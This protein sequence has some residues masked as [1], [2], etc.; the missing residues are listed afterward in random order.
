MALVRHQFSRLLVALSVM[1]CTTVNAAPNEQTFIRDT[2]QKYQLPESWLQNTMAKAH[3]RPAVIKLITK[4][5]EAKPWF[6]YRP[7]FLTTAR[8]N[9]GV[10]FYKQHKALFTKASARY[11]VPARYILAI[12]AVETYYG[13]HQGTHPVLDSLYTLGFDYPPRG[14][15]FRKELASFLALSHEQGWQPETI[16]GS[17]AGA[18]G[19]SQF[20]SSSYQHYAVDGDHDGKIDLFHSPADAINSIANYF[21][22]NGWQAHQPAIA[23]VKSATTAAEQY[24]VTTPQLNTTTDDLQ[25]NGVT[26]KQAVPQQPAMLLSYEQEQGAPMLVVGL[27]NFYVI[28]RYNRSPLYA[29]A[30]YQLSQAFAERGVSE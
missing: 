10:Q 14:D 28:T 22:E 16:K 25:A 1:A 24:V 4:P 15:F 21:A 12:L 2:A 27:Y 29:M 17:Y 20:I 26:L 30:V 11:H 3:H 19:M 23:E 8:I 6:Q 9:A 5:W 7:I 13:K 18:M